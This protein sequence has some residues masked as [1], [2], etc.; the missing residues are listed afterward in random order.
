MTQ[1]R[2]GML[3]LRS[4]HLQRFRVPDPLSS[5]GRSFAAEMLRSKKRRE[6]CFTSRQTNNSSVEVARPERFE[7]PTLCFEGRCSIQ[8]SYGR[9]DCSITLCRRFWPARPARW[10]LSQRQ[11]FRGPDKEECLCYSAM[12]SLSVPLRFRV[13]VAVFRVG[14]A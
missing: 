14:G 10:P 3:P 11:T 2:C 8:L 6:D 1:T 12:Q 5:K 13:S 9:V 4:C 7:L